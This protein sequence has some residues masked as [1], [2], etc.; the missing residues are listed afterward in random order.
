MKL[1]KKEMDFG[2]TLVDI[3]ISKFNASCNDDDSELFID[4]LYEEY[5]KAGSPKRVK[6]WILTRLKDEFKYLD[7]PPK[8]VHDADWPYC[9]G[10]PMVFLTQKE[11]TKKAE[12]F[13]GWGYIVYLF[14]AK[15]ELDGGWK[16]VTKVV[17]QSKFALK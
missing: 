7:E 14:G 3:I 17:T 9:N 6:S 1:D 4:R 15:M 5:K 10:K 2:G 12:D 11:V 8:W 13:L 16:V